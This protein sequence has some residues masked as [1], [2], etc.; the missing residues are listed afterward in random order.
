[1]AFKIPQIGQKR[2][3]TQYL[4]GGFEWREVDKLHYIANGSFG[5]VF[6]GIYKQENVVVKRLD[7]LNMDSEEVKCF[8]KEATI[9]NSLEHENIVSFKAFC[10]NPFAIMLEYVYFSFEMFGED[11]IVSS[12][13]EFL[14]HTD[15]ETD[16]IGF[17]MFA[18]H[19]TLD[20]AKGLQY[21]HKK[22]IVHRDLKPGN[23]LVSNKHYN[24]IF[25][26][27]EK[28]RVF[29]MK[30]VECK[31][32]DFGESRSNLIQTQTMVR[33]TTTRL[34]RGTPIYMAP[35]TRLGGKKEMT[36]KELMKADIW[37]LGMTIFNILNP[38]MKVPFSKELR[39]AGRD[40]NTA[41]D[42]MLRNKQKPEM[43]VKY[44]NLR[45]ND[46]KHV[47]KIYNQCTSFDASVR[48][49]PADII[50]E[51]ME[52][53]C[54]L[55]MQVSEGSSRSCNPTNEEDVKV[56]LSVSQSSAISEYDEK[57]CQGLIPG[58][59][60]R[61]DGTNA[62]SF[63]CVCVAV[64]LM[65]SNILP[66]E[67][68]IASLK[69]LVEQTI[70]EAP[71]IFNQKR[72]IERMYD[73][74]EA[75]AIL[76]KCKILTSKLYDISEEMVSQYAFGSAAGKQQ[77]EECVQRLQQADNIAAACYTSGEYILSLVCIN[78]KVLITDTHPVPSAEGGN[79]NGLINI[80]PCSATSAK[81]VCQCIWERLE[82]SGVH[83]TSVQSFVVITKR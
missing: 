68:T 65:D 41:L 83:S 69:K 13:S 21:L 27:E 9:L 32:T 52:T 76:D 16:F 40:W 35:E 24:G 46:W 7:Q 63:L 50:K 15:K 10:D 6:S 34:N 11:K 31:L 2:K 78:G 81:M 77:L 26:A 19:I 44:E 48:P 14:T 1:M 55:H 59:W 53:K 75:F 3:R 72:D 5:T 45:L 8:Q 74:A 36:N 80:I 73:I 62:C 67:W 12:L 29:F 79:G 4:S 66:A 57:I 23:V 82:S 51:L 60:P 18:S 54:N 47:Y 37:S 42:D 30:P 61:N 56:Q 28:Q 64:K 33:T 39:T 58:S 20:I 25:D 70:L 71:Y 38:D 43:S 17:E 49:F 22:D